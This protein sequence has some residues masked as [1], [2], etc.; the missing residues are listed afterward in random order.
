MSAMT[1]ELNEEIAEELRRLAAAQERPLRIV[2]RAGNAEWL[3]GVSWG[4]PPLVAL[5]NGRGCDRLR[6]AALVSKHGP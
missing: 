1:V 4:K 3:R 5:Q 2:C 6:R